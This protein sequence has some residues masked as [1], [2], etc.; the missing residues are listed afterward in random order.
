[1]NEMYIDMCDDCAIATG[2]KKRIEKRYAHYLD[3]HYDFPSR[4]DVNVRGDAC[5]RYRPDILYEGPKRI[6][7][8]EIDEHQHQKKSGT[9][10]VMKKEYQT[11]MMSFKNL[12]LI[13][14]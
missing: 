11:Y 3:K 6:L 2:Q 8:I 12:Y 10:L 5:T 13:I 1:M 4:K 9:I 7:H 14:T